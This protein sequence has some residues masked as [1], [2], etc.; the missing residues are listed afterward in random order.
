M[1]TIS[2][3]VLLGF[4]LGFSGFQE[5]DKKERKAK[6]RMEMAQLIENGRFRFVA[7]SANSDLGHF[8]QLT[9]TYDLVFDSLQLKA[10]LPYYGRAYSAPYGGSGGVKFDLTAGKIDKSWN[11]RKKLYTI[12]ADV[13]NSDDSYS[14]FLTAGLDGYAELKI[15]FRNRRWISY[16]GII[17]KIES[18]PK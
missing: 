14:I 6:Q 17:E 1:K 13:A 15:N 8:N 10:F 12:T 11:E 2:L 4:F 16:S 3:L 5:I 7:R 18:A 9:S